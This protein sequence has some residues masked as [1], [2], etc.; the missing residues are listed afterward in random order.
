MPDIAVVNGH[1]QDLHTAAIPATDLAFLRGCGAFETWRSYGGHPHALGLHLERLWQAAAL[2][3]VQ[4]WVSEAELRGWLSAAHRASTYQEIKVNAV[5][6]PGDHTEGVFGS[7]N[8]RLVLIVR[9]LHEPPSTWY[10]EGVS[11]VSHRGERTFPEHKT[12]NYLCGVPALAKAAQSNAHEAIYINDQAE[13]LEG[14]TSNIHALIGDSVISPARHCLSGITRRGIQTL[15]QEW[16]LSWDDH[17]ALTLDQLQQADEVWISS[18]IRELVPVVRV[19]GHPIAHGVPGPLAI[20]LRQAYR[21]HCLASAA[22][23]AQSCS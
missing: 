13:V 1:L 11:V 22:A 20:R 16:G 6:S 14:V 2:F 7:A 10:T 17:R 3:G 21:S 5:C 19:D 4:P 8:P 23:D 15:C 18:A 12:V 9:E